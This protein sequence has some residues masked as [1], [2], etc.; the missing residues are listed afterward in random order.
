MLASSDILA[1]LY[2]TNTQLTTFT[3]SAFVLM[4]LHPSAKYE[5][6]KTTTIGLYSLL[7]FYTQLK[8]LS[9]F[10]LRCNSGLSAGEY[11]TLEIP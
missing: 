1:V 5:S 4:T 9:S 3:P 10:F 8:V 7:S 11:A 2:I 6:S